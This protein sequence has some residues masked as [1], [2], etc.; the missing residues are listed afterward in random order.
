GT[1]NTGAFFATVDANHADR[2]FTINLT[3]ASDD[4]VVISG[5]GLIDGEVKAGRSGGSVRDENA[6]LRVFGCV[7]NNNKADGS[8]G[9]IS[10]Q[11]SAPSLLVNG[12][13]LSNNTAVNGSGG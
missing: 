10:M 1:D 3:A 13:V 11:P 2:H 8:G 7:L 9:G 6:R 5:L 12:S 4:A